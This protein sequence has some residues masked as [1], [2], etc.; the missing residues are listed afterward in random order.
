M[1]EQLEAVHQQ[2]IKYA[3]FLDEDG[4]G[5]AYVYNEFLF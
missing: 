2:T 4:P 5:G 1:S 3:C